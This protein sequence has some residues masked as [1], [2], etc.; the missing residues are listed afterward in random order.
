MWTRS[1]PRAKPRPR[2][3]SVHASTRN[4]TAAPPTRSAGGGP[5]GGGAGGA[6]GGGGPP[7]G[8]GRSGPPRGGGPPLERTNQSTTVREPDSSARLTSMVRRRRPTGAALDVSE[9][10]ITM[11]V[12]GWDGSDPT[13][14]EKYSI[15]ANRALSSHAAD[16]SG[17]NRRRKRP[18]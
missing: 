9:T 3:A 4:P 7:Q 13:G 14:A 12:S 10:R 16:V 18:A 5:P 8:W 6:W 1:G 15:P 2:R 17:A 11:P